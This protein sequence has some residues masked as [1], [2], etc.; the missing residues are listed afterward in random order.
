M[1]RIEYFIIACF[2]VSRYCRWINGEL[3]QLTLHISRCLE[4][5]QLRGP[6][7]R[8][9]KGQVI[10]CTVRVLKWLFTT[11]C[12][13]MIV[14]R[15]VNY[16][17]RILISSLTFKEAF[18]PIVSYSRMYEIFIVR[19]ALCTFSSLG[20]IHAFILARLVV[21]I[22]FVPNGC[23]CVPEQ[24]YESPAYL[25][26]L[27]IRIRSFE[28]KFFEPDTIMRITSQKGGVDYSM[29]LIWFET[30]LKTFVK[31]YKSHRMVWSRWDF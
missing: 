19:D 1:V 21:R 27:S 17:F 6:R 23:E 30:L 2:L 20:Q 5:Y 13:F 4:P 29:Y 7:A 22:I 25:R 24:K 16:Q 26:C 18:A 31:G 10:H 12:K 8:S 3:R 11:K 14:H 15:A 9:N 28:F